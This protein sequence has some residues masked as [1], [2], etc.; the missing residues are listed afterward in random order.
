VELVCGGGTEV[1]LSMVRSQ[2]SDG[3]G[4]GFST[5]L[6]VLEHVLHGSWVK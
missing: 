4:I 6:C 5:N 2:V 3:A 1:L